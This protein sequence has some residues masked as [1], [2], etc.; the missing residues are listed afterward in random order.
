MS[1][2]LGTLRE[3]VEGPHKHRQ[4]ELGIDV[5]REPLPVPS[6]YPPVAWTV[7]RPS[8][9][10]TEPTLPPRQPVLLSSRLALKM[11]LGMT[12]KMTKSECHSGLNSY[13]LED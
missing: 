12:K 13:R 6:L 5:K 2:E 10:H 4:Q 9:G 1:N 3:E 7:L 11:T 8:I